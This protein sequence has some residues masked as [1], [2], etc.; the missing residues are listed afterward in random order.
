LKKQKK[1]KKSSLKPLKSCMGFQCGEKWDKTL[2]VKRAVQL[3][4]YICL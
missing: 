1:K 4:R 2:C 3:W